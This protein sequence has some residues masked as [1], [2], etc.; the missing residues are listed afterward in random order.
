MLIKTSL[1][2]LFFSYRS[3]FLQPLF[4]QPFYV[5]LAL[6]ALQNCFVTLKL[7]FS[8]CLHKAKTYYAQT[9][10]DAPVAAITTVAAPSRTI[11]YPKAAHKANKQQVKVKIE[12]RKEEEFA[13][14]YENAVGNKVGKNRAVINLLDANIKVDDKPVAKKDK[15]KLLII[16]DAV[17][18]F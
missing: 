5:S 6:Y 1:P 13:I 2:F 17:T 7:L 16:D 8:K 4:H 12:T 15:K 18:T 9:A 14:S 10:Q 3:C 11:Q